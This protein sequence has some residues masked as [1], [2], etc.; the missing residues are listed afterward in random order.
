MYRLDTQSAMLGMVNIMA[1]LAVFQVELTLFPLIP[2]LCL[3]PTSST[4]LWGPFC[5]CPRHTCSRTTSICQ[6]S[7]FCSSDADPSVFHTLALI[8]GYVWRGLRS[9]E[10]YAGCGSPSPERIALARGPCASVVSLVD[11]NPS[12]ADPRDCGTAPFYITTLEQ[13]WRER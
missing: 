8:V 2:P 11:P 1:S 12:T 5:R 4:R 3:I 9:K 7:P 6:N 13:E 10:A